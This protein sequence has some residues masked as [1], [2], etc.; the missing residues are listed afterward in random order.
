MKVEADKSDAEREIAIETTDAAKRAKEGRNVAV[1]PG[2]K[3][4]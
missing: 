2:M 4:I 3:N 1:E